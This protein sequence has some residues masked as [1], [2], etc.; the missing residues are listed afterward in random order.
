MPPGTAV[1]ETV[2]DEVYEGVIQTPM[3]NISPLVLSSGVVS[4]Q[5]NGNTVKLL[6]G[7]HDFKV[8]PVS[9]CE[10]LKCILFIVLWMQALV[11]VGPLERVRNIASLYTYSVCWY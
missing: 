6:F 5:S 9:T 8:V 1:F 3:Y 10:T 4:Y 11:L 7:E 2:S